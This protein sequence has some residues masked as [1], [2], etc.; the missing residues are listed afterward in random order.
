[1]V[2]ESLTTKKMEERNSYNIL[3][4][5]P[6]ENGFEFETNESMHR[7]YLLSNDPLIKSKYVLFKKDNL[8]FYASD[9]YSTKAYTSSTFTG[10]YGIIDLPKHIEYEIFIKDWFDKIMRFDKIKTG[11]INTDKYL[12]IVSKN[13]WIYNE[14]ESDKIISLFREIDETIH[15]I[16]IKISNGYLDHIKDFKGKKVIGIETNQWI[17]KKEDIEKMLNLGGELINRMINISA[18]HSI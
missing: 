3:V 16:E 7:F 17:Y 15:P 2:G 14:N 4:D 13:E 9:S 1:M 8:I 18:K 12:T 5:Y 6:E 10:V 11:Q